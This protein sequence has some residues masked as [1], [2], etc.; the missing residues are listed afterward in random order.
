MPFLAAFA[1]WFS[2]VYIDIVYLPHPKRKLASGHPRYGIRVSDIRLTSQS[3]FDACRSW[4]GLDWSEGYLAHLRFSLLQE[5]MRLTRA[6][7]L[8]L[9][10]GEGSTTRKGNMH[11]PSMVSSAAG[12]CWHIPSAT[13][14]ST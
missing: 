9:R 6:L 2:G 1:C 12:V 4:T 14:G 10:P 11:R 13:T 8:F 3:M 5:V 7:G